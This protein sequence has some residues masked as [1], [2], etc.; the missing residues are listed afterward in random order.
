MSVT[1]CGQNQPKKPEKIGARTALKTRFEKGVGRAWPG[2]PS[3]R[4]R[5]QAGT[6]SS[7]SCAAH[8][9]MQDGID[10]A[11]T[12][13]KQL[14]AMRDENMILPKTDD[15]RDA[16]KRGCTSV[17]EEGAEIEIPSDEIIEVQ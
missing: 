8:A 9:R 15:V 2:Q 12:R 17:A 6:G 13:Q 16:L 14:N 7:E 11:A 10:D 1:A 4:S 5:A 3:G